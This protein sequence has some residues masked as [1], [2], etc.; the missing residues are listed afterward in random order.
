MCRSPIVT[1]SRPAWFARISAAVG[2]VLIATVSSA[3]GPQMAR[4]QWVPVGNA[5]D[6]LPH[7]T[8]G[9][10]DCD[11]GRRN[12]VHHRGDPYYPVPWHLDSDRELRRD[13]HGHYSRR[14]GPGHRSGH[15]THAHKHKRG[16]RPSHYWH[17]HPRRRHGWKHEHRAPKHRHRHGHSAPHARGQPHEGVGP[18][19]VIGAAIGGILGAHLAHGDAR[20]PAAI[21]GALGGFVIGHSIEREGRKERARPR[22][23][24]A[25][26]RKSAR[27]RAAR[28]GPAPKPKR[29]GRPVQVAAATVPPGWVQEP[30]SDG[31]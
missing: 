24:E 29:A 25:R 28:A 3:H 4:S 13:R 18:G 6:G 9:V 31:P 26:A 23:E 11:R 27:A 22:T 15:H 8:L 21:V 19:A 7:S 14:H 5:C 20:V 10:A 2:L 16:H 12:H 17:E 1:R 30:E